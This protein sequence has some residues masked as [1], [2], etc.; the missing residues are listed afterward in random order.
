[1]PLVSFCN[2]DVNPQIKDK[3]VLKRF[4]P[5]I[6]LQEE[7]VLNSVTI[8]FCSDDYLLKMNR[9]FLNHDFYT[10]ILTFDLSTN[11]SVQGE[12]Y[13]STDRVK[14]NAYLHKL[15]FQNE[16]HRVIFHGALHLC[17]Y[18]DKSKKEKTIMTAKE[19]KYLNKFLLFH[20]KQ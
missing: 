20:V 7:K 8:I 9:R 16:L 3:N 1:M 17:G 5:H 13:I 18:I 2:A 10:D 15:S 4:I 11:H 19:D 14:E 6:F 12:I